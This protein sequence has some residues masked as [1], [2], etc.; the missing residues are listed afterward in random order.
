MNFGGTIRPNNKAV[1]IFLVSVATL[2]LIYTWRN[3]AALAKESAFGSEKVSIGEI[4]CAAIAAA[5]AGGRE[6]K[7]VREKGTE[8]NEKSKG[9][10]KE[11]VKDV[12][13]D[14]DMRSHQVM[15]STLTSYFPHI[16]VISEE[17]DENNISMEPVNFNKKCPALEQISKLE[18]APNDSIT[19]WIDPLD[20]TKEYTENLLEYVTTMV[21]I[22]VKG[23]PV[24]GVIHKPFE[25]KTYWAWVGQ[26]MAEELLEINKA[27][28]ADNESF[29]ISL[30]HTGDAVE[31]RIKSKFPNAK[32]E[33]AG[34][35]GYKSLQI[36]SRHNAA[37]VHMTHIKKWDVCAGHAILKA[38]G[39]RVTTMKNEPIK[40]GSGANDQVLIKD[41]LLASLHNGDFYS[42]LFK[43]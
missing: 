20:A 2:Y 19:I 31:N 13:T 16:K 35:A 10:T 14:G 28:E 12:L 43:E 9:K 3:S 41:G 15:Y 33:K 32:V 22:A 29:I 6:V 1:A 24:V 11:G 27:P 17:H 42:K 7:A 37:Y 38:L 23:E 18:W 21:C 30:S 26:G 8:L 40:Y 4:L 25:K 36:A 5:E 34:G 39:G